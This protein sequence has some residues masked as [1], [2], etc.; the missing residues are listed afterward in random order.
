MQYEIKKIDIWTCA[1]FSGL[2][3]TLISLVPLLFAAVAFFSSRNNFSLQFLGI[4]LF[5]LGGFAIGFIMGLA[6]AFIYNLAAKEV[7]GIR[8][9]IDYDGETATAKH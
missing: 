4:F 6:F 2:F 9:D 3:Y 5:P 7:G 1:R 8:L